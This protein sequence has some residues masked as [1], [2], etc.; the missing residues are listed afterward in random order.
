MSEFTR[1]K[2]QITVVVTPPPTP[3]A[4]SVTIT[5]PYETA[6]ELVKFIG[7]VTWPTGNGGWHLNA[8]REQLVAAAV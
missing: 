7:R 4:A 1:I 2:D 5:M 8:I 6:Q 3:P